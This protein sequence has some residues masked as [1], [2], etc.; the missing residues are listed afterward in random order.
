MTKEEIKATYSMW[1]I[2]ARY[3]ISPTD[4]ASFRAPSTRAI[5]SLL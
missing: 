2:L 5:G 3:G 4:Q 1:D